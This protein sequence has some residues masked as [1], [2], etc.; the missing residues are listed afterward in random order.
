MA[1][2]SKAINFF[3]QAL[4]IPM[5]LSSLVFYWQCFAKKINSKFKNLELKWFSEGFSHAKSD[6]KNNKIHQIFIF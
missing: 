1:G 5:Y 4:C 2:Q 6:P 3:Y